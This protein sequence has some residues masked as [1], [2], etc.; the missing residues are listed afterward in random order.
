MGAAACWGL[1]DWDQM[2]VYTKY[3]P[4]N[5]YE[6]S[7]YRSV[8]A[9][10]NTSNNNNDETDLSYI[11]NASL[12]IEQT[13]DLLDP[14]LTSMASQSYERS[15]QAIIEAQVLS[16]LE[17]IITYK[18]VPTK[19]DWLVETWWKRLQGC[20]RS[21]EY[22]HRLLLVRTG[23]VLPKEKDIK[24]WLKFSSLCQKVGHLS[25]SQQILSSLLKRMQEESNA[26]NLLSNNKDHELCQ[27]AYMKYLYANGNRREAI[28]GLKEFVN[29][30]L[31]LKRNQC[32]QI[33]DQIT[34]NIN[35]NMGV[36]PALNIQQLPA[37]F[38]INNIR[39]LQKRINELDTQLAKCYL[40]LGK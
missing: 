31:M 37:A 27:Y 1:G 22:W 15:Y 34:A 38:Q 12:L 32:Q 36:G 14:D 28:D 30:D 6:G 17:E 4:E 23:I 33:K 18:Q 7:L 24:P 40:K 9:L 2:K 19:R 21:L 5:T 11:Q 35:Q 13:R 25:L 3:L 29:S 10:T 8:L 16:E 26:N 39:D 20:E